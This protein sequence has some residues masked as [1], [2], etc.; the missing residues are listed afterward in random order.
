M[1]GVTAGDCHCLSDE[2]VKRSFVS[3]K[4]FTDACS[5]P[6]S[7]TGMVST[8]CMPARGRALAEKMTETVNWIWCWRWGLN[9]TGSHALWDFA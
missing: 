3:A 5:R 4:K 9:W 7:R 2:P 8:D 6:S 1:C